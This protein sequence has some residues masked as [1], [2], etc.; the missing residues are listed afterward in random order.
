MTPRMPI[1]LVLLAL[2]AGALAAGAWWYTR[3]NQAAADVLVLHGNVDIR[4]VELAFNA[5]GRV[6]LVLVHEGDRVRKGQLLAT[7]DT[8][9]LSSAVAEAQAR[10]AA[11]REVAA[12][13]EAGSRPEEIRKA[14]ADAEAARVDVKNAELQYRR[15][16]ELAAKHYVTQQQ[17]DNARFGLEAAQARLNA[18]EEALRLTELGPR[19]ED[20]RAAK[21]TLAANEAALAIA[22]RDLAEGTLVAPSDGVIE[23]RILEPGDM[24]SPVKPALT[25]ALANPLWVRTY[26]PEPHLGKLRLGG[27]AEIA[28][29]TY[30]D[31][32][33]RGWIGF[34][35]PTAEFTPKSVETQEVRTTL[36][37]QVRVFACDPRGELRLGMPATVR[38]PLN[39][40]AAPASANRC[41]DER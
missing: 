19:A 2:A 36:V 15:Q 39:Q 34:I 29:D 9:R 24:A 13:L 31:A 25:L 35:S 22:Q 10:V 3:G 33:Y 30:P 18:V 37:Y 26:V 6:A 21:A 14:R 4:Q 12:R 17:V 41:P 7:I 27:S 20:K 28:T 1:V 40:P 32:R 11:Q 16:Q 5:N 8:E 23:N 38:I